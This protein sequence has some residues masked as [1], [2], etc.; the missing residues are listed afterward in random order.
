[1]SDLPHFRLL[2]YLQHTNTIS[3]SQNCMRLGIVS[4]MNC[5]R[6]AKCIEKV[7][8]VDIY[9]A[10]LDFFGSFLAVAVKK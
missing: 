3:S 6:Y 9:F 7:G 8:F 4:A 2:F 1:M 10:R 5:G